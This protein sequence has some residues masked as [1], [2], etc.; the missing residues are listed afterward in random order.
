VA[1]VHA[2]YSRYRRAL[3]AMGVELHELKPIVS[4]GSRRKRRIV[5][6]SARAS[7]HAK[8]YVFDRKRIVIG[9]M[10]LDPRSMY[11]NTELGLM[12]ESEKLAAEVAESF[13]ELADTDYSY[14]VE[15][16]GEGGGLRWSGEEN[17]EIRIFHHDPQASIWRRLAVRI[18]DLFPIE[19]QL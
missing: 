8:T 15:L 12:I 2:G 14:R 6:G 7:L 16:A 3:L 13:D 5:F 10:N 4:A 18:L 19:R 17:G 11:L 9:S 1:A